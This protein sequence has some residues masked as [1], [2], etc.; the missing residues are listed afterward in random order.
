LLHRHAH[1]RAGRG[2]GELVLKAAPDGGKIVIFVGKLDVQNAVERRQGL[3]DVLAGINQQE[4]KD[5]SDPTATNLEVGKY[6]LLA[7]KTDNASEQA[8]QEA[9]QAMLNA[10]PDIKVVIGLWEYNPPAL[11][12]AV[13]ATKHKTAIVGFDENYD[14]LDGIVDG[15]VFGT[16]VQNPYEFGYQS[17][18]VLKGLVEDNPN[19]FKEYPTIDADHR[20][21]IP[22]RTITQVN[23][24][25][26]YDELKVLKGK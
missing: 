16:I 7:T 19:V 1:Y 8:C 6:T 20:I 26:F 10:N 23:V 14:T 15:S 5:K 24:Q 2:A 9:A 13:K 3:L 11:I 25:K 22:H 17:I 18:K 12:R 4:M 21:F